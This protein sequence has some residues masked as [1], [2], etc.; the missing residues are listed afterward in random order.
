ML[1][2]P[3][4]DPRGHHGCPAYRSGAQPWVPCAPSGSHLGVSG[5]NRAPQAPFGRWRSGREEASA[6]Q[7]QAN[8]ALRVSGWRRA[9]TSS[10]DRARQKRTRAPPWRGPIPQE[11]KQKALRQ[12]ERTT[13]PPGP[14]TSIRS[15]DANTPF[16]YALQTPHVGRRLI[17]ASGTL[18]QMFAL[19]MQNPT[20]RI[21]ARDQRLRATSP[22]SESAPSRGVFRD[23]G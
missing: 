7:H 5:R 22:G 2:A 12:A 17:R 9:A 20:E 21:G 16:M 15:W 3:V 6:G 8:S 4:K 18:A 1:A 19:T 23:A 13:R 11:S 10:S 14:L